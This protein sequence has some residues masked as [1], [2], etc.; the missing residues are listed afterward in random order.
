[1]RKG[2]LALL[3]LLALAGCQYEKKDARPLVI[4]TI[5]PYELLLREL[6]GP[7][8][9]VRALIPANASPHTYS[10][11]PRDLKALRDA[12]LVLSNGLGLETDLE[13]AFAALGESHLR[14]EDLLRKEL[15][16]YGGNPHLWLSPPLMRI[17]TLRLSERLQ[18]MFPARATRIAR[19]AGDLAAAFAELDERIRRE[20]DQL[21]PTPLITFHDS[22]HWFNF[23]YRIDHLGSV[24]SS[25]GREPTPREISRLGDLIL[26]HGVRAVCV[27]PQMD[28]RSA[29]VLAREF[30]LKLIELDPLGFSLGSG[31]LP[32]LIADNWG[33]MKQAWQ[34]GTPQ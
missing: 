33:R 3:L 1:M 14:V 34:P 28:R 10:P 17:L 6:L 7:D 4:A 30:K 13:R 24:Q 18:H 25:P 20:R 16:A 31:T 27:E 29:D 12:D 11:G 23:A 22:F 19:R 15:P 9:E 8:F 2:L 5:R 26:T 32:Q 21:G